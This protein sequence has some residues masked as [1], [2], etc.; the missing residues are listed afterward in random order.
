VTKIPKSEAFAERTRREQFTMVDLRARL[1]DDIATSLP[2]P[3]GFAAWG[4]VAASRETVVSGVALATRCRVGQRHAGDAQQDLAAASDWLA[5]FHAA[6]RSA[7]V[8]VRAEVASLCD[9]YLER[10]GGP[11]SAMVDGVRVT[12]ADLP[13]IPAVIRHPDFNVW[14]VL[15][16]GERL[17]VIDWEGAAPGPPFCDLVQFAVHWHESVTRRRPRM[18]DQIGLRLLLVDRARRTPADHAVAVAFDRYLDVVSIPEG[19]FDVLAVTTWVELALRRERQLIDAGSPLE[20][21][22]RN[23]FGVRYVEALA[24]VWPATTAVAM[25]GTGAA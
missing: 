5:R 12:L 20:E 22:N 7:A 25:A 24:K 23:N 3:L 16:S 15:R 13:P 4:D 11:A 2:R 19:W 8:D 18:P 21:R 1:S 17:H 14:N 6:T 10:F 9:R